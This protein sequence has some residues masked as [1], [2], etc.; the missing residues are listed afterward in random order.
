MKR[1]AKVKATLHRINSHKQQ[2]KAKTEPASNT[3]SNNSKRERNLA[4]L[5]SN[6]DAFWPIRVCFFVGVVM[7][8]MMLMQQKNVL[9]ICATAIRNFEKEKSFSTLKLLCVRVIV[10]CIRMPDQCILWLGLCIQ[11]H[12]IKCIEPK[13]YIIGFTNYK[14][15]F[16]L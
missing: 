6:I 9:E 12:G 5:M 15:A 14:A 1:Y 10:R 7:M 3:T 16:V 4:F 2:Q 13:A 11:M 8:M